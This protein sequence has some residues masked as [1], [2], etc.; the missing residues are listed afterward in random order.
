MKNAEISVTVSAHEDLLD[1]TWNSSELE[2]HGHHLLV[3]SHKSQLLAVY[4]DGRTLFTRLYPLAYEQGEEVSD[5][6]LSA[7]MGG[8]VIR[9]LVRA[10]DEVSSGQPLLV[11]EAIKMDHTIAAPANRIMEEIFFQPG[12]IVQYEEE[13]VEFSPVEE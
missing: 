2:E 10:G 13:L 9:L 5:Y 3:L 11:M 1:L 8:N 12:K 4:E 6:Q 7:P